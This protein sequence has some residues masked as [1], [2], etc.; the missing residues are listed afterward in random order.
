MHEPGHVPWHESVP[1]PVPGTGLQPIPAEQPFVE[2]TVQVP[3]MFGLSPP[4]LSD[5]GIET[6]IF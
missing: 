6:H 3:V 5:E 1:E 4:S 2:P